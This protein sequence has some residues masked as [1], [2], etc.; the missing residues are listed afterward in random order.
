MKFDK[1][2]Q[3]CS[4]VWL[5][6]KFLIKDL[7]ITPKNSF[8][9]FVVNSLFSS[10]TLATTNLLYV[11]TVLLF[12]KC[13][14]NGIIQYVDFCVTSLSLGM[15]LF[16]F[17]HIFVSISSFYCWV[18]FHGTSVSVCFFHLVLGGQGACLQ[19]VFVSK[20]HKIRI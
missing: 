18:I 14:V 3:M 6:S 5:P 10:R 12:S 7:H 11:T 2:C 17:V 4:I 16:R 1:L 8:Y 20:T 15:M 13:H 19:F 9:T